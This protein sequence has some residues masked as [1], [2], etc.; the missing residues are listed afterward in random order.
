MNLIMTSEMN[1]YDVS[2]ASCFTYSFIGNQRSVAA[3][4][5]ETL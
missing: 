2:H 3:Y 5:I 4:T 1:D